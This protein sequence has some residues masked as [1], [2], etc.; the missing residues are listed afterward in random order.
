[1]GIRRWLRRVERDSRET[2]EWV[3]LIDERDGSTHQV[4][5]DAFL[6]ILGSLE[7]DVMNTPEE[8][9]SELEPW[10][11]EVLP[12]LQHLYFTDGSPFWLSDQTHTGKAA[13]NTEEK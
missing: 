13:S 11:L 3:V 2:S 9:R 7:P 10:M 5:R 8:E 4:P 6:Q 12:R 1:M